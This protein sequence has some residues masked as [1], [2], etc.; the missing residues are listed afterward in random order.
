MAETRGEPGGQSVGRRRLWLAAVGVLVAAFVVSTVLANRDDDEAPAFDSKR[1]IMGTSGRDRL[2]GGPQA[3]AIFGFGGDDDLRGGAG[4]DLIDGGN[5]QDVIDAGPG[6]DRIRAY[7]GWLDTVRCGAGHDVGFVDP[8]DMA[9]GCEELR[10]YA[11]ESAPRSPRRPPA[12]SVSQPSG[13]FPVTG[14][15]V[16]DEQ[17]YVCRGPVDLDLVK[18]TMRTT[19]DDAIRLD[20]DCSGRIGRIEVDTWTADGIKVQNHGVVAHDLVVESGYVK[21]HDVYGE[22]HQDGIQAMGGYRLTFRN[23]AVDCLGNANLFLNRGGARVSTP[24]DVVCE[25][26]ILGPNSA[27]TF[28]SATSIRSGARDTTVCTG[29]Y[30]AIRVGPRTEAMVDDGNTVLPDGDPLCADVTGSRR[31]S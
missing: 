8:V 14:R 21:C 6:D 7:D 22:Y 31:R 16:L 18:V 13:S 28:F 24:T 12:G 2:A 10:E 27:Q 23:L 29:R 1:E 4:G 30:R 17:A 25:R 9:A 15:I 5:R 3:D 26:C 11:D 20:K 19:V